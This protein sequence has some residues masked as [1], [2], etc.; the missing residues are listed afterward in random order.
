MPFCLQTTWN[1]KFTGLRNLTVQLG[2]QLNQR[3]T[4][5]AVGFM[6]IAGVAVV[7]KVLANFQVQILLDL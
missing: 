2:Q 1:Q 7:V 5:V 3:I 4:N 6:N